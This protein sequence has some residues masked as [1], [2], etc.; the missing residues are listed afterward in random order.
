M[1]FY[2]KKILP[3]LID[4]ACGISPIK[5]QRQKVVPQARGE[6]LEI[7]IGSGMNLPFYDSSTV[8]KVWGLEP[9]KE[10]RQRAAKTAENVEVP[11]SKSTHWMW[12]T[13]PA[14]DL[15]G[16]IIG[17]R[18]GLGD[19]GELGRSFPACSCQRLQNQHVPD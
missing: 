17:G 6:V 7:G 9:A 18:R 15:R 16:I 1:G 14:R 2:E 10:M 3:F 11:V 19:K 12:V 5:E 13:S 4:R 8:S